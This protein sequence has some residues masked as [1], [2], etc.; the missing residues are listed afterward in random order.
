MIKA[1]IVHTN[2]NGNIEYKVLN[3]TDY[4]IKVI[5]WCLIFLLACLLCF[6]CSEMDYFS[7]SQFYVMHF[8]FMC[9]CPFWIHVSP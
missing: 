4:S 8:C 1:E 5:G 2:D 6:F 9:Y 7:P 3:D